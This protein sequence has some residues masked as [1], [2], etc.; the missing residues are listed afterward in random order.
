MKHFVNTLS[1]KCN[2]SL[3]DENIQPHFLRRDSHIRNDRPLEPQKFFHGNA[4]FL[5]E[6]P[7]FKLHL[8]QSNVVETKMFQKKGSRWNML[9][10]I[11]E[12]M[13]RKKRRKNE[14]NQKFLR[15]ILV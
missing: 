1:L 9:S 2:L 12:K 7:P 15:H 14:F 3:S 6:D 13:Y 8:I 5:F 4:K 10:F 11:G